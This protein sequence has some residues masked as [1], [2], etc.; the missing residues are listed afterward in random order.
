VDGELVLLNVQSERYYGLNDSG[1][2]MW[3]ALVGSHDFEGAV[4]SLLTE[5]D[6]TEERLRADLEALVER[7]SAEGLLVVEEGDGG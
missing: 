5:H 7:L 3:R 4:A 1:T 2:R 6:V